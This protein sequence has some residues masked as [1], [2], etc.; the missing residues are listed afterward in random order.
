MSVAR[1]E[2]PTTCNETPATCNETTCLLCGV[3]LTVQRTG[4][5]PRFCSPR[6][7]V[8][9]HRLQERSGQGGPVEAASGADSN[10]LAPPTRTTDERIR[11]LRELADC[12]DDLRPCGRVAGLRRLAEHAD[13]LSLV[14]DTVAR[15]AWALEDLG[16]AG[17]TLES[18]QEHRP[19]LEQLSE[20]DALADDVD[21]LARD[22]R[23]AN[24]HR[25]ELHWAIDELEDPEDGPPWPQQ[26]LVKQRLER[27]AACVAAAAVRAPPASCRGGAS[28]RDQMGPS[29]VDRLR[30]RP[31]LTPLSPYF[32]DSE[33]WS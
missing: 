1:N 21:T 17:Y 6:H 5:P 30:D 16:E 12:L 24:R 4:R 27:V 31:R 19:T 9:Y 15:S 3:L 33:N 7:R 10:S 8:R 29:E 18:L 26:G 14:L 11:A 20:L 23:E 25:D 28:F 22:L 32:T 2:T 13:D